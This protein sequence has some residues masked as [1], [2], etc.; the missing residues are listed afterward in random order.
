MLSKISCIRK[1]IAINNW[2]Y[3]SNS[4]VVHSEI[5]CSEIDCSEIN[6]SEI[7]CLKIGECT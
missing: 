6:R 1:L 5:E 3:F 2:S 4:E 7:T